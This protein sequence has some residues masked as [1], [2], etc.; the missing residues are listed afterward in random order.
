MRIR[1]ATP[2]DAPSLAALLSELGYQTP[3]DVLPAR[4]SALTRDG[5]VA[6][7]AVG[8]D[9]VPKGL[10]CVASHV[11]IHASAPVGY[12]MA[13]VTLPAARGMG[14]G[15]ALVGA[16]EAWARERGCLRL[17]VTSAEHRA[18]AHA[19]YPRCGMPYTGRRFSKTVTEELP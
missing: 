6:L 19:F 15:R 18:D 5:S 12:I 10:V 4:L 17:T 1:L 2:N 16:A 9:D 7:V 8:E 3:V 14:V 11:T 13:L